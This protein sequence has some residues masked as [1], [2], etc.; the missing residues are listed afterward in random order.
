MVSELQAV[1]SKAHNIAATLHPSQSQ[2]LNASPGTSPQ[3]TRIEYLHLLCNR[4]SG[5]LPQSPSKNQ[6]GQRYL[7]LCC[8]N[9]GKIVDVGGRE[10]T[11]RISSGKGSADGE[12][13]PVGRAQQAGLGQQRQHWSVVPWLQ[14]STHPE[15]SVE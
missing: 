11:E 8:I 1:I 3:M 10:E 4:E 12:T 5:S 14:S 6:K 2:G 7:W 9:G 13:A 15:L